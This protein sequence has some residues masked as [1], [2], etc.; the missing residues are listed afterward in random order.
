LRKGG[1]PLNY[2]YWATFTALIVVWLSAWLLSFHNIYGWFTDDIDQF[3]R[4]SQYESGGSN[5]LDI[6]WFHAYDWFIALLPLLFHWSIPSHMMPRAWSNTGQFRAF[7][8]YVIVLHA[9]ILGLIACLLNEMCR[10]RVAALA[11][12]VLFMTSPTFVFY[13]DLLDSRYLGL[14][15]GIP[16]IL[17]MLKAYPT[18]GEP[19]PLRQT[20]ISFFLPGFLF[21]LGQSIH[22]TL[23]YFAGPLAFVYWCSAISGRWKDARVW[24]CACWFFSGVLFWFVPVEALSLWFHPFPQSMLGILWSQVHALSS[25][26][27]KISDLASWVHF[28]LDD[29]GLT[30]MVLVAIGAV[31]L[32]R[33][34]LRPTYISRFYARLMLWSSF[35]AVAYLVITPAIALYRQLSM[36]QI[37]FMLFV[38]VAIE[39]LTRPALAAGWTARGALACVLFVAAAWVPSVERMPPVF[40]DAQGLGRAVNTA[41]TL[42]GDKG[43]VYFIEFYDDDL[44]PFAIIS[45][46]D[47]EMLKPSDV[48]VTD[49]PTIFFG[50]YPDIFAL[51]H[52]AGTAASYPT[53][54][55]TVENWV[56]QRTYWDFRRYQDEPESCNAQVYRVSDIRRAAR[57]E[58]LRVASLKADSTLAD[59]FSPSWVFVPREPQIPADR[60]YC[61]NQ[62]SVFNETWASGAKTRDHWFEVS[63]KGRY[64]I[65]AVTVVPANYFAPGFDNVAR[66]RAVTIYGLD[67]QGGKQFLWRSDHVR[68]LAIFTATFRPSVVSGIRLEMEQP[69]TQDQGHAIAFE[70]RLSP[71]PVTGIE[72]LRFPGYSVMYDWYWKTEL[73]PR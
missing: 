3:T 58:P 22:Y 15:A 48:V 32:C 63:F 57:G 62:L 47:L 45:R 55:C 4:I 44:Y 8:L 50:K 67:R 14:L 53:E 33:N 9:L 71:S 2:W 13:A 6:M 66:P 64:K 21:G 11:A 38:A 31:I 35:I 65:G 27:G 16:A 41:Y 28:I 69:P 17:I 42:A 61:C 36:Y 34:D 1:V 26:Y 70:Q 7:I 56:E 60:A 43:R 46:Q 51:L 39:V 5:L 72:F 24:Q 18:I 29:M 19:R 10:N 54:W 49:F 73:A 37:F 25:D 12:L 59:W 20:L 30:M 68:D 23:T 52:D 40:I